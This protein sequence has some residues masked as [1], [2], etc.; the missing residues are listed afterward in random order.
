MAEDARPIRKGPEIVV[1]LVGA[2]GAD[3]DAIIS[4]L[5]KALSAVDYQG[6]EVNVLD[7][8]VSTGRWALTPTHAADAE[9]AE[10][11]NLGNRCREELGRK[12]ALALFAIAD[13]QEQRQKGAGSPATPL[14]RTAFLVRS[15]KTPEEVRRLREVYGQSCY[16]VA[17]YA[18]YARRKELLARRISR[19]YFGEPQGY[20][21]HV[22][23]LI[24]RDMRERG[25]P[26]GQNLQD[27][28]YLADVFI[29]A[30]TTSSL[31]ASSTRAVEI[32]F[33]HPW[34]TPTQEEFGM[35]QAYGA[36]LRSSSAGR[37]V[38]AAVTL[39]GE[40]LAVGTN[41]V[42]R[43][44][45]GQYWAGDQPDGRDHCRLHDSTQATTRAIFADVLARLRAHGWLTA[46]RSGQ[47]LND[48][49]TAAESARLFDRTPATRED[50]PPTI[51]EKAS[52][53]GLV[54]FMRAVHAEMAAIVTAAR[55]GVRIDGAT[56]FSTAFPC[57]ECAR[58]IV[59]AGIHRVYFIEPYPKSRVAEM[60]DDSIVIDGDE[61][62]L[63]TFRAF[64]G[65]AP[66]LYT[67]VFE[68]PERR[69]QGGAWLQ[70]DDIRL[71]ALPRRFESILGPREDD[72]LKLLTATLKSKEATHV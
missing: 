65:I 7:V 58:H 6:I 43:A 19:S 67:C 15:L 18:P 59:A 70:W 41:E 27:T 12:D 69:G 25:Q 14:P 47:S 8:I 45:G 64:T 37:Q 30:T 9:M 54:E 40:I 46:P 20:V 72:V 52:L 49:V 48:L 60:Y 16:I 26:Y 34:R 51:G 13:I 2:V 3:L 33:G 53:L 50:D 35:F 11:M 5:R 1:G 10:K 61:P 44:F 21:A 22:E 4:V 28:F 29:D 32:I 63:V 31:E 39:G 66:R 24:D 57:H 71:T 68:M 42:P 62:G 36:A 23:R 38:G 55:R 56:L 17:A